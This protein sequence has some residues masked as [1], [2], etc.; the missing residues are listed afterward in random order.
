MDLREFL[1]RCK[2]EKLR[3]SVDMLGFGNAASMQKDRKDTD[4]GLNQCLLK[5]KIH[6]IMQIDTI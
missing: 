5:A 1:Y 2:A 4:A 6:Q 3:I